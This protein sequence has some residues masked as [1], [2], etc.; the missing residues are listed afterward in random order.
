MTIAS[1]RL[2]LGGLATAFAAPALVRGAAAQ[3]APAPAAA[4]QAPGYYRFKVGGFT[5]TTV[6]DGAFT[7][8]IEAFV[9]NAPL[10]DVQAVLA[11]QFLP[12]D[13][14]RIPFTVTFV[15]T[16]TKLVVFDSGNGIT[17]AT[18]TGRLASAMTSMSDDKC[19]SCPSILTIRSFSA[20]RRT[21]IRFPS[22]VSKSNACSGWPIS[23]MM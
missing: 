14:F 15:Q 22:S 23:N 13:S 2:A 8:P 6:H 18:A 1:R 17:P 21:T 9:R 7:R 3:T 10:A 5:V 4:P 12:T 11:A 19:R 20:A 16:P